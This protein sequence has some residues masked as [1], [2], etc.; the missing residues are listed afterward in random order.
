MH[1]CFGVVCP[2]VPLTGLGIVVPFQRQHGRAVISVAEI[3]RWVVAGRDVAEG[4]TLKDNNVDAANLKQAIVAPE[5][6]EIA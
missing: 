3:Q 4:V 1:R 2:L 5:G 6:T